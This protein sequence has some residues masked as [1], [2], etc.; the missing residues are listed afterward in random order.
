MSNGSQ[1]TKMLGKN[2]RG[3]QRTFHVGGVAR[4]NKIL[5]YN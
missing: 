1:R 2:L 4:D 5:L 3:N